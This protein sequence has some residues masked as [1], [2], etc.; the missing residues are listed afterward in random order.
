MLSKEGWK[1][2]IKKIPNRTLSCPNRR[3]YCRPR[4]ANTYSSPENK[5]SVFVIFNKKRILKW[6]PNSRGE[7]YSLYNFNNYEYIQD[8]Y[9]LCIYR[10]IEKHWE[11]AEETKTE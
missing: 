8:P 11:I 3:F 10:F 6:Y 2:N 5:D 1:A 7:E 9:P 4:Y